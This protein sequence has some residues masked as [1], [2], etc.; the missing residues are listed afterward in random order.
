M[1]MAG[2]ATARG[3][4][5]WSVMGAVLLQDSRVAA[6]AFRSAT[7][8]AETMVL[9]S[10]LGAVYTTISRPGR[11]NHRAMSAGGKQRAYSP[12]DR[13]KTQPAM[14]TGSIGALIRGRGPAPGACGPARL[15]VSCPESEACRESLHPPSGQR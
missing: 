13:R 15:C 12:L 11:N 5:L 2:S 14:A 3:L 1:S 6:C 10:G 8:L 7:S 4:E 9:I